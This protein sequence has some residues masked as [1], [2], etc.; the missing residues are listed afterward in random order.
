MQLFIVNVSF[1]HIESRVIPISI[2]SLHQWLHL[3]NTVTSFEQSVRT[4]SLSVLCAFIFTF[5][6][7]SGFSLKLQNNQSVLAFKVKVKFA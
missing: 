1:I 5:S 7:L 4:L 3:P 2:K 6:V